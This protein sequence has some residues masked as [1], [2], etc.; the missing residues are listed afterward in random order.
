MVVFAAIHAYLLL[1]AFRVYSC[2]SYI[3]YIVFS[4]MVSFTFW[5]HLCYSFTV[6]SSFILIYYSSLHQLFFLFFVVSCF[7]ASFFTCFLAVSV[8]LPFFFLLFLLFYFHVVSYFLRDGWFTLL[9]ICYFIDTSHILLLFT[10]LLPIYH[11]LHIYIVC[12]VVLPAFSSLV[13]IF[14]CYEVRCMLFCAFFCSV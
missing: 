12:F 9:S 3:H 5:N 13:M 10:S 11:L 14:V 1:H 4:S 7:V 2:L 8:F 6:S